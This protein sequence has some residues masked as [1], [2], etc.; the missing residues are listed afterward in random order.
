VEL[1]SG[2]IGIV[3]SSQP[4]ARLFPRVML[5]LDARE[6][7]VEPPKAMNLALFREKGGDD[8]GYEVKRLVNAQDYGID[9]RSYVLRELGGT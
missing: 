4:D 8:S 9:V 1:R 3:I 5:I 2:H 6:Q 7:P